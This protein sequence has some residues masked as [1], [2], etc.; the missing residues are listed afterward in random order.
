MNI[1]I[2][3]FLAILQGVT[4]FLPV[5]S[6]GHLAL[7]HVFGHFADQGVLIDVALHG[8]TLIAVMVYFHKEL[9]IMVL[10][11]WDI[12]CR[13]QT[14]AARLSYAIIWSTIPIIIGGGIMVLGGWTDMLRQAHIIAYASIGFAIPLYIADRFATS[15]KIE[16]LDG[17]HA[18]LVGLAQLLALIPGASRSGVTMTMGRFLGLSRRDAAKF[19]MLIAM[20]VIAM[21]A[22]ASLLELVQSEQNGAISDAFIGASIAAVFAMATIHGFLWLTARLSYTPFVIYRIG[23]GVAIL[24]FI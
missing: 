9:R 13:R 6:S 14:Q 18:L 2:L 24:L 5:S 7:A 16:N 19:S 1:E 21:F 20:P 11:L 23:L 4:E 15:K 12:L 8:G 10:G 22:I 17:R 3:A